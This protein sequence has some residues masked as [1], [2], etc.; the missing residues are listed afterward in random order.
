MREI[1]LRGAVFSVPMFFKKDKSVDI[2]ALKKYLIECL[3]SEGVEAIFSMAYNTRYR[4][5]TD[6]ELFEVNKLCCELANKYNKKA[7][8]GHAYTITN[9]ELDKYCS[10]IEKYKPYAI[11]LLYPER[12]YG[13]DSALIDFFSIP[14]RS[15]IPALIHEQK[16]VSGFNGSLIDWP[17]NLINSVLS[18]SNV[19]AVKEDSKNDEVTNTVMKLSREFDF[20]VIVAGGGKKRV[21]KLIKEI[22]LKCW[23]NGS[24]MLFPKITKQVCDAYL[25]NDKAFIKWYEKEIETPYFDQIISKLG[26]HVGHKLALHV[27]GYCE[28]EERAPMPVCT[29]ESI[30]D[31]K[32]VIL[33]INESVKNLRN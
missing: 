26:W 23:L 5:L 21:R 17:E 32:N 10:D 12:Y 16:L 7:I 15:G 33:N 29:N 31:F 13:V 2:E 1:G 8:I 9:K 28:L 14:K 3:E 27:L 20:D 18:D 22:N 19:I 6:V 11:S 25:N 30:K 24:L 4:Q